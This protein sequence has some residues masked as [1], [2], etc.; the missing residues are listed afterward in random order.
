M[1]KKK[2]KADLAQER[3]VVQ[4]K[5]LNKYSFTQG[6]QNY[7]CVRVTNHKAHKL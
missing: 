4:N 2:K 1:K 6:R 7:S 3:T 5:P